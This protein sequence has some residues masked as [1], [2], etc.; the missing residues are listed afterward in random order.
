MRL[1]GN[2]RVTEEMWSGAGFLGGL[3]TDGYIA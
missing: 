2:L 1:R 3:P